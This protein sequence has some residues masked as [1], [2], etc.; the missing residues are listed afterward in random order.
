MLYH[1]R[2]VEVVVT[3]KAPGERRPK[4]R[5]KENHKLKRVLKNYKS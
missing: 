3:F 5:K 1:I 2:R 4:K